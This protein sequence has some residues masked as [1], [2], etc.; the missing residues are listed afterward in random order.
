M[1]TNRRHLTVRSILVSGFAVIVLLV[2]VFAIV[3][4]DSPAQERLERLDDRRVSD[5][6]E[7]SYAVDAYWTR[8]AKLPPSL[9]ELSNEQRIVTEIR[10]PETGEQYEYRV[11]GDDGYELC[12]IFASEIDA[13][14][15]DFPHDYLWA[16]GSGR[17][18]FELR[19]KDVIGNGNSR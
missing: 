19:A 6:R 11:L 18:C 7:I 5:L 4:L 9:E 12:A 10:D 14:G 17:Q 13:K 15:R 8:E 16:H 3:L 1:K 2:V